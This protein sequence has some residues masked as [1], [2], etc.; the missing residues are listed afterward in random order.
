MRETREVAALGCEQR[1]CDES[2]TTHN[3]ICTAA[4][5]CTLDECE[6]KC[7]DHTD[8]RAARTRTMS[9]RRSAT[10]FETCVNEQFDADYST[11]VLQDPTCDAQRGTTD[12]PVQ[13]AHPI[14]KSTTTPREGVR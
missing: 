9:P 1:R 8:F 3:K 2:Q 13:P 6:Q 4:T 7:K 12:Q 14:D 10:L 5:Q 11:Y